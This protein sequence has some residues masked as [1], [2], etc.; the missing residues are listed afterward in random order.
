MNDMV[1][2]YGGI[3]P[4]PQPKKKNIFEKIKESFNNWKE[5]RA[6]EKELKEIMERKERR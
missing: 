5:Q 1:F 2:K 6:W 4:K 3:I